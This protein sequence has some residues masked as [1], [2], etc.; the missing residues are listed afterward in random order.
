MATDTP[1][2]QKFYFV[3]EVAEVLRRSEASV[4][5]LI[6]TGAL[7]SGRMA[8]RRVVSAAQLEAFVNSAFV[9]AS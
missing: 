3:D 6:H 4:R 8:G 7:K 2:I 5:W 9:E 1:Q